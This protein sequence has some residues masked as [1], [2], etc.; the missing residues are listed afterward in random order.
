MSVE[1]FGVHG[2]TSLTPKGQQTR[3]RIVRAATRVIEMR[4]VAGTTL[5]DIRAEARVSSS[6]IYHYF[7]DRDSLILAAID[8]GDAGGDGRSPMRLDF[9]SAASVRAWGDE[10][11]G[12][13]ECADSRYACPLLDP[14]GGWG[15]DGLHGRIE[16][17]LHQLHNDIRAGYQTMQLRGHIGADLDAHRLATTTLSTLLGGLLLSH[18]GQ[19]PA[20]FAAAVDT[21]VDQLEALPRGS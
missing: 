3:E 9:T 21:V 6:Q 20:P 5:E 18:L 7:G 14:V 1:R 15:R 13:L 11:V 2:R 10:V 4:G 12:T 16:S 17:G 8:G 19:D